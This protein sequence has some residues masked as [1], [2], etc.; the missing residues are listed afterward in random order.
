ML[1]CGAV[2]CGGVLTLSG[3]GGVWWRVVVSCGVWSYIMGR[4]G[5]VLTY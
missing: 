2:M 4:G 1:V 3:C 5:G